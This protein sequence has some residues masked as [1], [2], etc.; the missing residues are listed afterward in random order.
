MLVPVTS[1]LTVYGIYS[2]VPL[3]V[4][5]SLVSTDCV[6]GAVIGT[7]CVSVKKANRDY[8]LGKGDQK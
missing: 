2:C 1:E 7:K 6:P 3:I 8:I 4:N 5:G